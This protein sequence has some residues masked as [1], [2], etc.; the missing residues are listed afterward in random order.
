MNMYWARAIQV[1]CCLGCVAIAAS[2]AFGAEATPDHGNG[3]VLRA[4]QA[5]RA[6]NVQQAGLMFE[7]AASGSAGADAE[8]GLIRS[9]MQAGEYRHALA[10]AAHTAGDHPE[11]GAGPGLYAWLLFIGGQSQIAT[12]TLARARAS[13]PGDPIL[14]ATESLLASSDPVAA[15]L[16]IAP[17]GRYAPYSPASEFMP[18]TAQPIASGLLI[19]AART[20]LTS[21]RAM[22]PAREA[23]IRDG[24]GRVAPARV[25]RRLTDLDLVELSV[26]QPLAPGAPVLQLP[27]RDPFPGSA[28]FAVEFA[29]APDTTPAWPLMRA[30]FVGSHDVRSGTYQLGIEVP[31]G[32][33]GGPVFDTAGR[34]VGIAVTDA[35]DRFRLVPA[36]TLRTYF[37]EA[38][39]TV[40]AGSRPRRLSADE[41]YERGLAVT[42]QVIV[43]R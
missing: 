26:D 12:Q 8:L 10:L 15:G 11:N 33:R 2:S 30:G 13:N 7:Q 41:I 38:V 6:G 16:L 39:G 4:E 3:I 1:A 43:A 14:R 21:A 25:R 34:L 40:E 36:S 37:G 27:D 42:V 22:G 29:R 28:G 18:A 32:P 5:L 31:P 19:D 23:W 17:P 35:S 24:L 9:F 20:V